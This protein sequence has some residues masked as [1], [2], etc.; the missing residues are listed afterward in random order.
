MKCPDFGVVGIFD[1]LQC[2]AGVPR[3]APRFAATASPQ[4]LGRRFAQTIAAG[5]LVTVMAVLRQAAL[6]FLQ[7]LPQRVDLPLQL[8]DAPQQ[9]AD[10]R[11]HRPPGIPDLL[12]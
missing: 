5:R 4:A 2:L 6:E 7:L 1:S 8:P 11:R 3:L 10:Q 9:R 12:L